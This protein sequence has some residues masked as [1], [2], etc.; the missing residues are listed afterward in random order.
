MNTKLITVFNI[1]PKIPCVVWSD[2]NEVANLLGQEGML[3]LLQANAVN[4][5]DDKYDNMLADIAA[6]I[7]AANQLDK[8][9]AKT[10]NE[11]AIEDAVKNNGGVI[12]TKLT[13]IVAPGFDHNKRVEK[14]RLEFT[15]GKRVESS[16]DDNPEEDI[17]DEMTVECALDG[18]AVELVTNQLSTLVDKYYEQLDDESKDALASLI[19]VDKSEIRFNLDTGHLTIFV[20]HEGFG[21]PKVEVGELLSDE[22]DDEEEDDA[23]EEETIEDDGDDE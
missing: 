7:V 23:Y 13:S 12:L 20:M 2:T 17:I 15:Q 22:S 16:K 5:P 9:L 14:T 8:F 1:K 4:M 6:N 21:L 10:L 11:K 19:D 18:L 3:R